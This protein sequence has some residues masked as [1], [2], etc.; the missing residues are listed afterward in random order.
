MLRENVDAMNGKIIGGLAVA[1]AVA[2]C[3]T[4]PAALGDQTGLYQHLTFS[5]DG[6][7][8]AASHPLEG[9]SVVFD[10]TLRTESSCFKPTKKLKSGDVAGLSYS[11]SY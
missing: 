11:I 3:A 8:L 10:L 2:G 7:F 9:A 5:P 4:K 1:I 6:R